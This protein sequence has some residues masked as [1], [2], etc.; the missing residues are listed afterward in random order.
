MSRCRPILWLPMAL[1][2]GVSTGFITVALANA[3]GRA[4]L[5]ES[6]TAP[7]SI[8]ATSLRLGLA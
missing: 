5:A 1:P 4:G 7:Q 8:R 6:V 2:V 3:L